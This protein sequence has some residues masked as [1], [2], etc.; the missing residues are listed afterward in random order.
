MRQNNFLGRRMKQL[1]TVQNKSR[2]MVTDPTHVLS[3]KRLAVIFT[4]EPTI[5]SIMYENRITAGSNSAITPCAVSE[6]LRLRHGFAE[7]L[8]KCANSF[9]AVRPCPRV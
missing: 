3:V 4:T 5:P 6:P 9:D 1:G 7:L 2:L 8:M